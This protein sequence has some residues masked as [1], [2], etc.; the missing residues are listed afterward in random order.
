MLIPI[1]ALGF[2]GPLLYAPYRLVH[3]VLVS[4]AFQREQGADFVFAQACRVL[5]FL[6]G[7]R[8]GILQ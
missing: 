3:A 8:Q 7:D 2:S 5:D 1:G 6:P 4:M